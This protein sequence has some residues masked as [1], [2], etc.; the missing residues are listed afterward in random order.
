MANEIV[1]LH[2]GSLDIDSNEGEGTAVTIRLPLSM[3]A[4]MKKRK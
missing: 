3:E 2:G 4:D 1:E